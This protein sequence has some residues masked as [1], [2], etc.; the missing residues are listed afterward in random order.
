MK[1]VITRPEMIGYINKLTI[2]CL[3]KN[4]LFIFQP[5]HIPLK[6][7]NTRGVKKT[8]RYAQIRD[9]HEMRKNTKRKG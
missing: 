4:G 5:K 7:K 2:P 8:S 6:V 3:K 9:S 1:N